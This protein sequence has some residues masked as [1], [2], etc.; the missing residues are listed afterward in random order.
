MSASPKR[1]KQNNAFGCW[2][3]CMES[4]TTAVTYWDTISQEEIARIYGGAKDS[5][6]SS[7]SAFTRFCR[8]YG[9]GVQKFDAGQLDLEIVSNVIY[10]PWD[11]AMVFEKE[12]VNASHARLVYRVGN[13]KISVMEPRDGSLATRIASN[14]K[15]TLL[16]SPGL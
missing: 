3:A 8:D 14:L 10:A 11:Y 16:L 7:S 9:L 4:W 13:D 15:T 12:L 2:A 1:V 6:D 5:L